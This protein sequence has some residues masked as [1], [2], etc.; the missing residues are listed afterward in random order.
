MYRNG[1]PLQILPGEIRSPPAKPANMT[2]HSFLL[3]ADSSGRRGVSP[4]V[5]SDPVVRAA[6]MFSKLSASWQSSLPDEFVGFQLVRD[7]A[8]RRVEPARESSPGC[9]PARAGILQTARYAPQGRP[10]RLAPELFGSQ[11][12]RFTMGLFPPGWA[13]GMSQYYVVACFLHWPETLGQRAITRHGQTG[14][15]DLDCR[16]L[17]RGSRTVRRRDAG[18]PVLLAVTRRSYMRGLTDLLITFHVIKGVSGRGPAL[19]GLLFVLTI[20]AVLLIVL[21]DQ[22]YPG[23]FA[24]FAWRACRAFLQGFH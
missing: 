13:V 3:A 5:Y 17:A 12:Y 9:N 11:T 19:F 15:I 8:T 14:Y 10:P 4:Q 6:R 24:P 21:I 22:L 18:W 7:Q 1:E 20:P 16:Q 23:G 2:R